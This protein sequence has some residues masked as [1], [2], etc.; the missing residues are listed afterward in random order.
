MEDILKTQEFFRPDKVQSL[1]ETEPTLV[2]NLMAHYFDNTRTILCRDA[3]EDDIGW[4][5]GTHVNSIPPDK[6]NCRGEEPCLPVYWQD[7]Y[8]L[9]YYALSCLKTIP[10]NSI[11]IS[12]GESPAK[13]TFNI[14]LFYNNIISTQL[15]AKYECYPKDVQ[16]D[17]FPLSGLS[18]M[19]ANRPIEQSIYYIDHTFESLYASIETWFSEND[20]LITN[21]YL[22]HFISYKMDPLSVIN[23]SKKNF[24]ILDRTESNRSTLAF[25]YLYFYLLDKQN[26]TNEQKINFIKKFKLRSFDIDNRIYN[27]PPEVLIHEFSILC[28]NKMITKCI[29]NVISSFDETHRL[30]INS[31]HKW[32]DSLIYNSRAEVEGGGTLNEDKIFEWLD[33][34]LEGQS[35]ITHKSLL[36]EMLNEE[37]EDD[38]GDSLTIEKEPLTIVNEIFNFK[39]YPEQ[40]LILDFINDEYNITHFGLEKDMFEKTKPLVSDVSRRTNI[41]ESNLE[42][43]LKTIIQQM[44]RNPDC[45]KLNYTQYRDGPTWGQ[46]EDMPSRENVSDDLYKNNLVIDG[47]PFFTINYLPEYKSL[48]L[49]KYA[50]RYIAMFYNIKKISGGVLED[51]PYFSNRFMINWLTVPEVI[52]NYSRC[53]QSVSRS[54]ISGFRLNET[55]HYIDPSTGMAK[56]RLFNSRKDLAEGSQNCNI[57][58]LISFFIFKRITVNKDSLD[59]LIYHVAHNNINLIRKPIGQPEQRSLFFRDTDTLITEEDNYELPIK[60]QVLEE[61][62]VPVRDYDREEIDESEDETE[63]KLAGIFRGG[64]MNTEQ[65]YKENVRFSD[66]QGSYRAEILVNTDIITEFIDTYDMYNSKIQ[67][68]AKVL[69]Y[70]A[71]HKLKNKEIFDLYEMN[72][73]KLSEIPPE[74][75][76]YKLSLFYCAHN[77]NYVK[78]ETTL[79]FKGLGKKLLQD[80]INKFNIKGL[81]VL[82]ADAGVHNKKL[83]HGLIKYYNKLGFT[84]FGIKNIRDAKDQ[85][86]ELIE[87]SEP[88]P[89]GKQA[90]LLSSKEID[91]EIENLQYSAILM[92][93]RI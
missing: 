65:Y 15:L 52:Q 22:P 68:S 77:D 39:D 50:T 24:V 8:G 35:G 16:F 47:I 33:N 11:V 85:F 32:N 90:S 81:L 3:E 84:T 43:T 1:L 70:L 56:I 64:V 46:R 57:L 12:L 54:N 9:Y 92:A 17:Y 61:R 29:N 48:N 59:K 71:I 38:E 7:F 23:N 83:D 30:I 75:P 86:H 31:I 21:N 66:K 82:E 74:I 72:E 78:I 62:R 34:H 28:I 10:D 73:L 27:T 5:C 49:E 19:G 69:C 55:M 36:V 58:N 6:K 40:F 26:L 67:E 42:V 51:L 25:I 63:S 76:I 41:E 79:I 53:I 80:T 4:K 91:E 45:L 18:S 89:S 87:D 37:D 20:E 88:L 44:I 2:T 93:K 60:E 14:E 13:I